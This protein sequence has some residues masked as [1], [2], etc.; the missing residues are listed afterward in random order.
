[1]IVPVPGSRDVACEFNWCD[2]DLDIGGI[3]FRETVAGNVLYTPFYVVLHSLP[4]IVR[5]VRAQVLLG[6]G[7]IKRHPHPEVV[8]PVGGHGVF[9]TVAVYARSLLVAYLYCAFDIGMI[10]PFPVRR[11]GCE[12]NGSREV[13][14]YP[15]S[16]CIAYVPHIIHAP[17]VD[18]GMSLRKVFYL[19]LR[20]RG[21]GSVRGAG[22][23]P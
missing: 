3:G 14:E 20:V 1:M 2:V 12:E 5:H 6:L 19:D 9:D 4:E 16:G 22:I 15:G 23:I 18:A 21:K 17:N 7:D 10:V 11:G 8:G 13:N